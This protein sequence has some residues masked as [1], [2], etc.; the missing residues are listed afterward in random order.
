MATVI[1]AQRPYATAEPGRK[2]DPRTCWQLATALEC[3]DLVP[4]PMSPAA[5]IGK[6]VVRLTSQFIRRLT[7]LVL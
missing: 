3:D 1:N 7:L 6:R 2:N 5:V 4:V